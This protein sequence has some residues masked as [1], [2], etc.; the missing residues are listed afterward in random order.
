ME[1]LEAI[2]SDP[3]IQHFMLVG[4]YRKESVNAEH[5]VS[6]WIEKENIDIIQIGSFSPDQIR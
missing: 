3:Y 5:R 4:A 1:I 2:L 6:T